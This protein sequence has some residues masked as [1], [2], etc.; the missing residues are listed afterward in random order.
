[1]ADYTNR[2]KEEL[3]R[4]QSELIEENQ[5][6]ADLSDPSAVLAFIVFL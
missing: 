1:M 5:D 6:L 4:I 2:T 3:N